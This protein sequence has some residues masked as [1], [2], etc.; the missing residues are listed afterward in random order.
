M[1]RKSV[2]IGRRGRSPSEGELSVTA[3]CLVAQTFR[4]VKVFDISSLAPENISN[5]Q[6]SDSDFCLRLSISGTA[7][8]RTGSVC[9]PIS[10]LNLE[11][12]KMKHLVPSE[13]DIHLS[14]RTRLQP[15]QTRGCSL[16]PLFQSRTLLSSLNAFQWQ[17]KAVRPMAQRRRYDAYLSIIPAIWPVDWLTDEAFCRHSIIQPSVLSLQSVLKLPACSAPPLCLSPPPLWR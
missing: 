9:N 16:N 5:K 11:R 4:S 1:Q 12:L 3:G 10:W 8:L 14:L 2:F 7:S 6:N 17:L 15:R 13:A